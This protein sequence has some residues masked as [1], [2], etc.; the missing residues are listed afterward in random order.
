MKNIHQLII[1][2]ALLLPPNLHAQTYVFEKI[3]DWVKNVEIPDEST[4][5]RYDIVSGYYLTLAD[6]QL[7]LE[8]EALFSHEV[9]NVS[10]YSGITNASQLSINYDTN[11]QKLKIH[12]LYIWRK[13]KK[14]DRTNDLS[15][16][17]LNNEQNLDQGI[18]RGQITAYDILNDIRKDDLIDFAYTLT[19]DNP[20]FDGEKYL[21]IP[22]QMMN[23]MDL[24]SLCIMYPTDKNYTYKCIDCDS[25]QFSASVIDNYN[26]IEIRAENV[27]AF[28]PEDFT[29]PWCIPYSYFTLSSFTSWVDVNHWAQKVFALN[30]EPD[31]DP[32]FTELFDGKETTDDKI[33]KIIDYV[34][35]DI[36]YMGI[37]SGIGSI[38]PFPPE[39]VVTKRFGD[40]KDK[41]LLLTS[42]LKKI[43]IEQAYPALVNTNFQQMVADLYP[44]NEVFNHCIV[45]FTY[46]DSTYWVDPSFAQ[47]GGDYKKLYTIDY[48]KA[49]II[50]LPGDTLPNMS[51]RETESGGIVTDEFTI[52]SFT[53]PA[54]LTMT[55]YKYGFDADQRRLMM[56]FYSTKDISDLVAKDLGF[57][58]PVVNQTKEPD[59]SDDTE[60][61]HFTVAYHYEVD[62]FWRDGDKE[63][64]EAATGLWIFRYEPIMLYHFMK[65]AACEN[66]KNDFMINHPTN[67]TYRVIFHFPKDLLILDDMKTFD[68]E[69]FHIEEKIEQ[70]SSNSMQI[71][72]SFITKTK[73]IKAENYKDIC[74]QQDKIAKSLPVIIFFSK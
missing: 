68:N 19:G 18:Y 67:L 23:P 2:I 51:P 43:G 16:E 48:G 62:D 26:H 60:A 47:Q 66:R 71:D 42:L 34:Q 28:E 70:I 64:N 72:Y 33:N 31:L 59:I 61:N 39:Q 40:C 56:E 8:E 54:V 69:A 73:A 25:V 1:F 10:S 17:I 12:H 5:S 53:E 38:Q 22:L 49:L 74:K 11:Y 21:L 44:S 13:G 41:S 15:L 58:F 55:S 7:N 30:K 32:V 14:I 29:P 27:K 46:N 24:L 50:G 45:T 4:V 6:Y 35:N 37:E 20:I 36:R 65:M 3:P 52:T 9:I 57:I 63:K